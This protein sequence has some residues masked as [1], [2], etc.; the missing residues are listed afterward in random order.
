MNKAQFLSVD[1]F[2]ANQPSDVN[3]ESFRKTAVNRV[4][5]A[6]LLGRHFE[7]SA[8]LLHFQNADVCTLTPHAASSPFDGAERGRPPVHHGW[9]ELRTLLLHQRG[10]T[11]KRGALLPGQ[12]VLPLPR[13][14]AGERLCQH[15]NAQIQGRVRMVSS[16]GLFWSK[17]DLM[18]VSC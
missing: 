4:S 8:F 7:S 15:L 2:G 12:P 14:P 10:Q 17:I 1:A 6:T 18:L 5:N 3:Q 16:A 9:T 13:H 11:A